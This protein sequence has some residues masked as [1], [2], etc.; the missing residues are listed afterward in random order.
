M[1]KS[2]ARDMMIMSHDQMVNMAPWSTA[3]V[4]K[5]VA[6]DGKVMGSCLQDKGNW[7]RR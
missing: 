3:Y 4:I 5:A 2:W 1:A 6:E 7:T